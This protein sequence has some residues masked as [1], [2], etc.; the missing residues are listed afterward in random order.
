MHW[1][2][3]GVDFQVLNPALFSE[4]D[5]TNNRS[6]V[7]RIDN[8]LHS[9]LLTGDAE[10]LVEARLLRQD[11]PLQS[12]IL[13]APHHGSNTSSSMPFIR[14]VNP[15]LIV[16]SAGYN[17]RFHHPSAA[18]LARYT[19][20]GLPW[21]ST[22]EQGAIRIQTDAGDLRLTTARCAHPVPWRSTDACQQDRL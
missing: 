15:R 4:H 17:N 1:R 5:K 3:E 14:A 2:W 16:I 11:E 7:L 8:G 12:D 10:Q 21:L 22:A 19:R 20:R 9:V 13:V 6:C 18:V